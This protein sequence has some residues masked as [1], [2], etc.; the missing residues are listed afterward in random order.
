MA[1]HKSYHHGDLRQ[2]LLASALEMLEEVGVEGLSLRKLAA[3]VGVS[4]AA[5]EHHFATLKHLLTA[6]AAE[7]FRLFR[8]SMLAG[9]PQ[10]G[11]SDA[12]RLRAALDGYLAYAKAHPQLL[13]LMFNRNLLDWDDP[14]LGQAGQAARSVLTEISRPV[15]IRLGLDTPEGRLSVEHL[16]WAQ[17]HGYAHLLIDGKV[18]WDHAAADLPL[19]PPFDFTRLLLPQ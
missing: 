16:V 1:R 7:G 9:L 6:L 17:A 14:V 8:I 19:R 10:Q 2:A 4:H 12:D 13:R 5:P 15:A 3:R 18:E 11:A